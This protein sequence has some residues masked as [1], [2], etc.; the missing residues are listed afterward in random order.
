LF[1]YLLPQTAN[2]FLYWTE[3]GIIHISMVSVTSVFIVRELT[4]L[5]INESG[6]SEEKGGKKS[7]IQCYTQATS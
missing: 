5:Y 3:F 4:A 2:L 1:P 7:V 6:T